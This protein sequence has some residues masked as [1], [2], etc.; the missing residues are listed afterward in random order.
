LVSFLNDMSAADGAR[1][2][3]VVRAGGWQRA[4]TEVR[5]EVLS[6]VND[7]I[8]RLRE[9]HGLPL[10]DDPLPNERSSAFLVIRELFK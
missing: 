6:L 1:L 9:R 5:F 3:A 8:V 4:S 7:A 10:L 2:I